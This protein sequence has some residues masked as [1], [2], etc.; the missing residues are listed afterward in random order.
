MATDAIGGNQKREAQILALI[1]RREVPGFPRGVVGDRCL[2]KIV[3]AA[4]NWRC[5]IRARS[6]NVGQLLGMVED[7]FAVR[8]EFEFRLEYFGPATENFVMPIRMCI[9]E[10]NRRTQPS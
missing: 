7:L 8:V 3:V 1:V 10:L 2:K 5:A 9:E 4:H 6:Y